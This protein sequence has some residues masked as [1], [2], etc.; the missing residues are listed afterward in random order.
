M[1]EVPVSS[2]DVQEAY[3]RIGGV[4]HEPPP[5]RDQDV[6]GFGIRT[7]A[8]LLDRVILEILHLLFLIAAYAGSQTGFSL[9]LEAMILDRLAPV[10]IG[11]FFGMTAVDIVYYTYLHGSTGQT[12]GK[13]ICGLKV[14]G[15]HGNPIGYCRAFRRWLGYV[16]S[17]LVCGL[18]FF[19]VAVDRRS[20]GW[21]DKIAKTFVVRI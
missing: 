11:V 20:Q 21:H 10:A 19:W 12:V 9:P 7:L 13:L 1:T 2:R 16:L 8:Y 18:G 6:A 5:I 17:Y 14:V 3:P 15:L 4:F